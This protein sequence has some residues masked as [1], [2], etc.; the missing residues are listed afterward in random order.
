M[1]VVGPALGAVEQEVRTCIVVA[2]CHVTI[3]PLVIMLGMVIVEIH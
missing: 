3:P 1:E 2:G